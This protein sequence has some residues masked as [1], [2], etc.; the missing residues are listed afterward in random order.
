MIERDG[1][2][3]FDAM[4]TRLHPAESRV[5]KLAA[6]IPAR[7]IAFDILLWE[8]EELWQL[9][10]AERR[11]ELER[12]GEGFALSPATRDR[13]AALGWLEHFEAAGL[14]GVVAKRTDGPI[15]PARARQSS[16]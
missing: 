10:L 7:F 1:A 9:P 2:L 14:D 6:E 13:D 8:G 15:W 12:R 4:Q 16:R 11:R 3:D 5:R